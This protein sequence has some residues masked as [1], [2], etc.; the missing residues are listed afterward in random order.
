MNPEDIV[1]AGKSDVGQVR[2]GNEDRMVIARPARPEAGVLLVVAD[3]MGGHPA[4]EEASQ[5]AVDH[6]GGYAGAAA[7]V[8][9]AAGDAP[10]GALCELVVRLATEAHEAIAA[11]GEEDPE[12]F[13]L[14]CTLVA[15]LVH[16]DGLFVAHTGDSR[17]YRLRGRMLEQLTGDHVVVEGGI[18]YLA[19]HLGMPEGLYLEQQRE[20][21]KTGD[22]LLLCSDGL[23][24]MVPPE[25]FGVVLHQASDPTEAGEALVQ[26]AN[27]AGGL[28]NVTCVVGFAGPRPEGEDDE[29]EGIDDRARPM[30]DPGILEDEDDEAPDS[31]G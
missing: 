27:M 23:T 10:F 29:D 24:D 30:K 28:D 14:G 3:G 15:V 26:L 7:E 31:D 2:P 6:L 21:V 8:L 9:D 19:A 11:V 25:A 13:G 17:A 22:R 1:A 4:G 12:K 5:I 20:D 16:A 18:R